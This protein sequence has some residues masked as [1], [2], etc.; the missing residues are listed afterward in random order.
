[1]KLSRIAIENYRSVSRADF[2]V[3]PNLTT[4]VGANEHGK[5]NLLRAI[6][7]LDFKTPIKASD[8][9]IAKNPISE[10]VA[11]TKLYYEFVLD[12]SDTEQINQQVE[13]AEEKA[14]VKPVA[15]PAPQPST[16][17]EEKK[18][19]EDKSPVVETKNRFD[20][21]NVIGL[22]IMYVDGNTNSY[23]VV[24]PDNLF[25]NQQTIVLS[26]IQSALEKNIFYFDTFEDRLNH[27]IPKEEI[28]KRTNDVTNGLIKLAGLTGKETAIFEDSSTARQLRLKGG[29]ELTKQLKNLWIQ[30]KEDD[31]AVKLELS[32]DG[33]FLNIDIE[34]FNTYGDVST[35]SRGF[36]FFL[37]FTLKFKEYY[38]GDLENFIFL[39][40]EPGI[41]LHPRG[42]K[43]L[44]LYLENLSEFNQLI[45]TTHSPFMINRLN[46][47]RVRVV[48]KDKDKGTQVDIKPYT[49]NWKSLRASLGMMLADSFYYAD[50]NLVV[51]G[52][53][54]RLFLLA[55]LRIFH[56][57][58]VIKSD[59]NIL[60]IVDSGGS[61]NVASMCRIIYSEDRPYVVLIDSDKSGKRAK[62]TV[63]KFTSPEKVK[64][65][66]EFK[67][68][69]ITLE[70]VLP[71]KY[72]VQA[73]NSYINQLAEEG[74]CNKPE[75]EFESKPK[76]TGVIEQLIK[77]IADNALGIEEI[78]KLNIARHFEEEI[79]K[80]ASDKFNEKE[81][82]DSKKL[83]EWVN[84][85]LKI[86]I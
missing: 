34:D 73:I 62:D 78:S 83:I 24:Q 7:L 51:E 53:S 26:F 28:I 21:K 69:A 1:M 37:A 44:L 30:G 47:F 48:S 42:Q 65:V 45:Y 35:R 25:E 5:T 80:I 67:T 4:I 55:L 11:E 16:E 60:S 36:L 40:D 59:L 33:N 54:D 10:K 77:Y 46:N 64:E 2:P 82:T 74:I 84:K 22:E 79:S 20:I 52:P 23:S 76:T 38:D 71:R 13:E 57:N 41:F 81:F 85:V 6:Q 8:C 50:N 66:S 18:I 17:G 63:V 29:E 70:D 61:A 19:D 86:S 56:E 15:Q 75:K 31:I 39:I 32:T 27:R 49:H 3:D 12:I 58:N 72:L 43:D 9:R 68:D 14:K